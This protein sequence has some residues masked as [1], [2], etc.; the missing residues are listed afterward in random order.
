MMEVAVSAAELEFQD[1][2]RAAELNKLW[3]WGN[4]DRR[5]GRKASESA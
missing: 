1:F 5:G 3:T 2:D 4:G